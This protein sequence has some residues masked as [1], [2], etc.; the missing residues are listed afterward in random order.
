MSSNCHLALL[1]YLLSCLSPHCSVCKCN[2]TSIKEELNNQRGIEFQAVDTTRTKVDLHP[3]QQPYLNECTCCCSRQCSCLPSTKASTC[4]DRQA[5][6]K[7]SCHPVTCRRAHV[8]KC[9]DP[10]CIGVKTRWMMVALSSHMMRCSSRRL[11]LILS[12]I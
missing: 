3:S 12:S 5:T 8:C 11:S 9:E 7:S 2:Y 1:A 10:T 4:I 6:A